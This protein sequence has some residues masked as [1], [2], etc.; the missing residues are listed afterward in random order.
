MSMSMS[1]HPFLPM[2]SMARAYSPAEMN[3]SAAAF[4]SLMFEAHSAWIRKEGK[5]KEERRKRK[6]KKRKRRRGKGEKRIRRKV[7]EEKE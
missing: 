1:V 7:E 3:I 4:G 5:K 2:I 6:R